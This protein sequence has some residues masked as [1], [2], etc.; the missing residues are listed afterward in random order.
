[1][2]VRKL[3]DSRDINDHDMQLGPTKLMSC[4]QFVK[5]LASTSPPY[6]DDPYMFDY[7]W[8]GAQAYKTGIYSDHKARFVAWHQHYATYYKESALLCDWAMG[9]YFNPSNPD[10]RGATPVA[11]P[12][13]IKAV[14]GKNQSFVDGIEI[15][16]RAWNL[17]RA[18]FVMQGRHRD[19][20]KFVGF[21]YRP[22]ASV[23][24]HA[25]TLPVYNGSSWDWV[26][27]RELYLDDKGVEQWKTEF[28]KIEGWDP[29]TGYPTR[30]TLEQ[31]GL[32]Y[33]ADLLQSKG[34][35]GSA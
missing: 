16:R 17:K 33:V 13:F 9:N 10:G 12:R 35:V 4:E 14:T 8:Q 3:V 32:K 25:T 6:Q 27:C 19:S 5:L 11:E 24:N 31:L 26:N 28:Y 23:A 22:G 18:I 29:N 21:M 34:R 2:G 15:G 1:M 20:E 7:S 30:P